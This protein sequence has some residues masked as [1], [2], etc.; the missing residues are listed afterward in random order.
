M[1]DEWT[2]KPHPTLPTGKP[3]LVVIIDGYGENEVKDAYNAVHVAKT[4]VF[5][6]LRERADR[7]RAIAAHGPAVG[8]PSDDDM[9]NSEVGH[10]ALGAGK[11]YAQGAKLVDINIQTGQMYTDPGWKYISTA[12]ASNTLHFIGLLS[13]GGVHSRFNQLAAMVKKAAEDG[14]KKIRCHVMTDGRDVPDNTGIGFI[15]APAITAT[16]IYY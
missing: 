15:E 9:G 5:D 1:A 8:L 14:A 7:F 6:K 4:P 12:F 2:L 3:V 16:T 13:D 11:I 10:N